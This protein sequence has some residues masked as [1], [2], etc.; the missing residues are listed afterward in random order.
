VRLLVQAA[1]PLNLVHQLC[2]LAWSKPIRI[3]L[4]HNM[5]KNCI[6]LGTAHTVPLSQQPLHTLCGRFRLGPV[7]TP[8][9]Q[10]RSISIQPAHPAGRGHRADYLPDPGH[11]PAR[12]S[13]DGAGNLP[14][15]FEHACK[16]HCASL[17]EKQGKRQHGLSE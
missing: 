3:V 5:T 12:G 15:K 10:M 11:R 9:R 1:V 6:E 8:H 7:H 13:N 4:N 17:S 2:Q 16:D 14:T